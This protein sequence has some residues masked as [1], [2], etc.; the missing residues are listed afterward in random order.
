[1]KS[2]MNKN[3]IIIYLTILILGGLISSCN[4]SSN[5]DS[6]KQP[7]LEIEKIKIG[8]L[9]IAESLPLFVAIEQG[10]IKNI[11]AIAFPGGAQ[12]LEAL[13][14]GSV[15]ISFSNIVSAIF[16]VNNGIKLVSIWG[17][18]IEDSTHILHELIVK[19]NS[20]IKEPSDV[21]NKIIAINNRKNIDELMI[22]NWLSSIKIS[23]SKILLMEVPFPRMNSVLQSGDVDMIAVVEPYLSYALSEGNRKIVRYYL[24]NNRSGRVEI[25]S[26]FAKEDFVL[27]KKELVK[28]FVQGMDSAFVYIHNHPNDRFRFLKKY[29]KLDSTVINKMSLPLFSREL[30]SEDGIDYLVHLMHQSG[31]IKNEIKRKDLVRE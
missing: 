17:T 9:P 3:L 7:Y 8:Y 20:I 21:Y 2:K 14:A 27:G 22:N 15:D 31:W 16:A 5:E 13:N 25:T 18:N 6:S 10:Y 24:E 23:K 19:K 11:D 26:Y 30:P 12:A 29:T 4:K 1:M 28:R